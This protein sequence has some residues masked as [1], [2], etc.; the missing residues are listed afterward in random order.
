MKNEKIDVPCNNNNTK[1][2]YQYLCQSKF[3]GR[4]YHF[5]LEKSSAVDWLMLIDAKQKRNPLKGVLR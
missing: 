2:L 4:I 1:W 3:S 5:D